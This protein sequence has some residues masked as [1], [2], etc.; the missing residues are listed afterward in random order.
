VVVWSVE[1]NRLGAT[2]VVLKNLDP[3]EVEGV[4]L[5]DHVTGETTSLS[6]QSKVEPA[7]EDRETP[8]SRITT[9]PVDAPVLYLLV[10]R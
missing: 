4:S 8:D 1:S 9:P 6:P 3:E 2:D 5:V 10:E 7:D